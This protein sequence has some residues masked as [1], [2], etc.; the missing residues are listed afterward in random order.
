MSRSA[1]HISHRRAGVSGVMSDELRPEAH[2]SSPNLAG[3]WARI[4]AG[5]T[6]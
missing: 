5:R 1:T 2:L 4:F 6:K 3:G